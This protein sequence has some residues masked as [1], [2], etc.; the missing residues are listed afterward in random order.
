MRYNLACAFSIAL[1]DREAALEVLGPYFDRVDSKMQLRHLDADPDFD[2]I[3]DDPR[4][5]EM[6]AAAKNRLRMD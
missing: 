6:L 3:R 2:P 1:A 5:K 4:F